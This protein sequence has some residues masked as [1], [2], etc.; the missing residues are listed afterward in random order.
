[1]SVFGPLLRAGAAALRPLD[2]A[3]SDPAALAALLGELGYGVPVEQADLDA[4][5]AVLPVGDALERLAE[6]SADLH[7]DAAL[8]EAA[9]LL[10]DVADAVAALA[11][12]DAGDLAALPMELAD[13]ATWADV[14][15]A[16]PGHLLGSWIATDVPALAA[17]LRATGVLTR[18][19]RGGRGPARWTLHWER[20]GSALADPAAAVAAT[21]GWPGGLRDVALVGDL[22]LALARLGFPVA[23]RPL[24]AEVRAAIEREGTGAALTPVEAEVC[25]VSGTSADG[26][27]AEAGLIFASAATTRAPAG[28]Y[29]GNQSYGELGADL[30]V[31]DSWTLTAAGAVQGTATAGAI[32]RP[33]AVHDVSTMPTSEL[34]L[35]LTGRP[36][37]PWRLL[38][39]AQGT[40]VE[41]SGLDVALGASLGGGEPELWVSAGVPDDGL[42]VVVALGDGDSFLR[43]VLGGDLSVTTTAALRWSTLA[44]L[45]FS[46]GAGL[47]VTIPIDQVVGPLL[48]RSARIA[49]GAG[50]GGG[51]I[52]VTLRVGLALGPL[53]IVVEDLGAALALTAGG[54]GLAAELA[55]VPPTGFGVTLDLEA[56]SGGGYVWIEPEIGRYTGALALEFVAV[57]LSAVVV[58]DTQL[59]GDPDGWALFAS[60]GLTFPS[61]PLGFGFFLSGVGGIVC[62]NRT[63]DVE[64]L[65]GGLSSGAVDAI[66]FPEDAVAAAP[67]IVSLLDAWFPLAPGS[68][69]FGV[70]GRITW[71]TPA[72][73]VTADVGFALSFPELDFVVLG[74]VTVAL[75]EQEPLLELH[76]D[77]LGAVDLSAGT[78]LVV[79]SLHDSSLLHTISLAGGMAMYASFGARPYFLLSIGGYH[80]DFQPPSELPPAVCELDRMRAEVAIS[81]DIGVTLEAYVAVTSNTLQF[82]AQATLEASDRFLGVTYTARGSAGFDVLLVLAPFSFS[83]SLYAGVS[84]TAGSSDKELL[85]VGLSAHLEGPKPWIVSGTA[86]FDFFGLNVTFA[87]SFGGAT[88]AASPATVDVLAAVRAALEQPSAWRA[89]LPDGADAGAVV[90][91]SEAPD[92]E[93]W[94]RPDGEL[95]VA[96]SVAPLDRT[97]DH[98]GVNGIAGPASFGVTGAGIGAAEQEPEPVLD[99]FSPA[100]F[101]DLTRAEKLAAP[102]YE[103]MTAGARFALAGVSLSG[104]E[105]DRRT[106]TPDYEVR[107]LDEEATRKLGVHGGALAAATAAL[108][109]DRGRRGLAGRTVASARFTVEEAAWTTADAVSGR[110]AGAAGSYASVLD[111]LH[112]TVAADPTARAAVRAAPAHAVTGAA[113]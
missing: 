17:A 104:A 93:L 102:S 39:E 109:L 59:P 19:R 30:A 82:G 111:D 78:V 108:A 64:A 84:V 26:G 42:A 28:L 20:L 58:V 100:Q 75:P 106:V 97:L 61:V 88:G 22:G 53:Q 11:R 24:T 69:V 55:F 90:L 87:V 10:V 77:V 29:V 7:G 54:D 41:L 81:D 49:L 16:L 63:L 112:A 46:G 103:E 32:L 23:H 57:G 85:A 60:L 38:G 91:A 52:E 44:G 86:E 98:Y 33:G 72:T 70:A 6:L 83:A 96:Q 48:M 37:D 66:L 51:R 15:V 1:M 110:A 43:G 65:A 99:W 5:A 67:L 89:F 25:L 107:I 40:R 113:A 47:D 4:I 8:I 45:T 50:D 21:Y 71:G 13:P 74:S 101:D 94:V 35:R 92:G 68:S 31:S 73:V 36:P 62:L 95:E 80:P 18:E 27:R 12:L 2:R 34:E 105:A 76:M 9:E 79:A 3:L 56:A 14:G